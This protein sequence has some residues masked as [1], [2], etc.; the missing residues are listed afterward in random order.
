[1]SCGKVAGAWILGVT[2]AV[3]GAQAAPLLSRHAHSPAPAAPVASGAASSTVS[4][5]D[6]VFDVSVL[7]VLGGTV[8]RLLPG[9]NGDVVGALLDNGAELVMPPGLAALAR[10]LKP[11][12]KLAVRGLWSAS[13]HLIRAFALAGT[14]PLCAIPV[15]EMVTAAPP[16]SAQGVIERLL[17]D[18]DGAV[19]GALLKDGTVLRVPAAGVKSSDLTPGRAVYASGAGYRT[20]WGLLVRVDILGPSRAQAMRVS[21]EPP[22]PPGAAAGSPAYDELGP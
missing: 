19:N 18:G 6:C 4:G 17:H 9:T 14:P 21:D 2:L 13:E 15:P 3:P 7:P 1:M 8:A 5:S 10:G 12:A 11:G 16:V 22:I 20:S